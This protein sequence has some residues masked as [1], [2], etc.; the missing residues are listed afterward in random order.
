[1]TNG[2]KKTRGAKTGGSDTRM[3]LRS[4]LCFAFIYL[5][6][7]YC[8]TLHSIA[9]PHGQGAPNSHLGV[10][11]VLRFVALSKCKHA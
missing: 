7:I 6:S 9:H 11:D 2:A 10:K 3:K 8:S 5:V 4:P 1:M